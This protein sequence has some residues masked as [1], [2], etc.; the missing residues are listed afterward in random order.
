MSYTKPRM[1]FSVDTHFT[2][3][4]LEGHARR[5]PC[6]SV[7]RLPFCALGPVT[8]PPAP[9][10]GQAADEKA[11]LQATLQ[12]QVLNQVTGEPV[13]KANLSLK[14]ESVGTTLNGVTDNEGK[15]SIEHID[16]RRYTLAAERQGLISANYR[17]SPR[18]GPG[19]T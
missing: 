6:P 1:I 18:S 15:F 17:A 2:R 11:K 13:R 7:S 16:P 9:P 4:V 10:L 3:I 19:T 12:G 5:A 8:H 14:P